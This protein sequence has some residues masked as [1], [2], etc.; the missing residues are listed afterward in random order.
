MSVTNLLSSSQITSLIQQAQAAYQAPAG[1]LQAQE[2]PYQAQVTALAAVQAALS[3]LQ[4]AMADLANVQTLAQRSV[5]VSPSGAVEATADN[6]TA[7]G[8][9]SLTGIHLAA[10]ESLISS[11]SASASGTL[12]AGT[13]TIQVG[14]GSAVNISIASGQSSLAA[15]AS[16]IDGADAGVQASVVFDGSRYHLVLNGDATGTANAFTISATGAL[17][18]LSYASGASGL[19]ASQKAADAS[20]SLEGL[21]ITSGS[22]AISGVVPGLS[23][24]LAAS[25]SATVTVSQDTSA[26]DNAAQSLVT[27]LNQVLGTINKNATYSQTSGA[28]PL[29]GDVGIEIIRSDLLDAISNPPNADIPPSTPYSSLSSVGFTVTSGGTVTFD[30]ST[31]QKAA[32]SN[33]TAVAALLGEVGQATNPNVAVAGLG[34]AVP[35]SYAVAVA[36]NSDGAVSGS[37][38]GEA[39]NGTGGLLVVNGDG[40]ALGLSLQIAPGATGDL[41][42]VTI[43]QGIFSSLSSIINAA[44]ASGTGSVAGQ[45]ADLNTTITT[46]NTQVNQMLAEAQQETQELTQQYSV[47][48]ATLSQLTTVSDFLTTYFNQTSGSSG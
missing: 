29:F 40:T 48:Q 4:S 30:Q 35:G 25:G 16:A 15:I 47:A 27:A 2:K 19:T 38:N 23:L 32:Q 11:G 13:L 44:V 3:G 37:V 17:A 31:F 39:A 33:Y 12:G 20:F 7:T 9:Y 8:T 18:G 42:T 28:G 34:S 36:S 45:I 5:S 1:V 26:L 24:T 41:G 21:T 10:A 43:S 14:S 22:N 6:A 46:M